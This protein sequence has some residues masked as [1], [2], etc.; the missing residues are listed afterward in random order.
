MSDLYVSWSEYHHKIEN[1]A[2]KIYQ[3]GWQFNQIVCI[4]KGGLR[5]GDLICRL[6][7][8]PLAILFSS[9]YGGKDNR[10]RGKITFSQHLAMTQ[11]SLGNKVLLV[12]DLVDS[13]ISLMEAVNWLQHN[14]GKAITEIRTGVIWYK[15]CS[16]AIPDYY[17]DYLEDNPW[18]HQ[19]FESYEQTNVAQLASQLQKNSNFTEDR[20]LI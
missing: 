4:A 19:P 12:D 14:H 9:S 6:Y 16:Q 2:V 17:V 8:Q 11:T 20:A 7:R 1:L 18:I 13:G 5:V 15:S 3:S 10:Q